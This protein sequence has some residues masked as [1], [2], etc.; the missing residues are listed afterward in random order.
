M[1]RWPKTHVSHG[2]PKIRLRYKGE[3]EMSRQSRFQR[4]FPNNL[5]SSLNGA[6]FKERTHKARN[7]G[8]GERRSGG[9]VRNM[10]SSREARD[11]LQEVLHGRTRERRHAWVS[12]LSAVRR[13]CRAHC[14]QLLDDRHD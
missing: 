3:T 13:L 14:V 10:K 11:L 4:Q 12:R 5:S 1:A 7:S 8:P 9:T 2:Y 6:A